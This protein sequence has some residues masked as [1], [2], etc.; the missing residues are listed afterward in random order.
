M[1][2]DVRKSLLLVPLEFHTG[3][4]YQLPPGV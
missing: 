3:E 1:L 4:A 2:R